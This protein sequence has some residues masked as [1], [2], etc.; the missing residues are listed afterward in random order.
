MTIDTTIDAN[1]FESIVHF[2]YDGV[3]KSLDLGENPNS[4]I[5]FKTPLNILCTLK[6]TPEQVDQAVEIFKLLVSRGADPLYVRKIDRLPLHWVAAEMGV[7]WAC[8]MV[9]DLI[10]QNKVEHYTTSSTGATSLYVAAQNGHYELVENLLK[11]GFDP[12][13]CA[14]HGMTPL[15]AAAA[16]VKKYNDEDATLKCIQLLLAAGANPFAKYNKNLVFDMIP[17]KFKRV[18]CEL[19]MHV[20]MHDDAS[21]ELFD[22]IVSGLPYSKTKIMMEWVSAILHDER[23]FFSALFNETCDEETTYQTEVFGPVAEELAHMMVLTKASARHM[24]R[25]LEG[26][27]VEEVMTYQKKYQHFSKCCNIY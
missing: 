16:D 8:D 6:H 26:R 21:P 18:V 17:A 27:L 4:L 2:D 19:M 13:K 10:P 22:Y 20:V 7:I 14:V 1:L 25:Y 24:L 3:K 15:L 12:N 5:F 23:S 9:Y 11:K